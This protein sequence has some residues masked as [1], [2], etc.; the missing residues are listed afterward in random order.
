MISTAIAVM[1]DIMHGGAG[2]EPAD[3]RERRG[4]MHHGRVEPR[5]AVGEPQVARL[6]R[7]RLVEQPLDLVDQRSGAGGA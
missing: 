2:G 1:I 6:R 4:G 7:H 5:R 3:R